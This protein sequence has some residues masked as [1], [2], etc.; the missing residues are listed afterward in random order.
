MTPDVCP[1]RDLLPQ[2]RA[3]EERARRGFDQV[4][5]TKNELLRLLQEAKE[6]HDFAVNQAYIRAGS[7]AEHHHREQE[8]DYTARREIAEHEFRIGLAKGDDGKSMYPN[9]GARSSGVILACALDSTYKDAL[10][11]KLAEA[12]MRAADTSEAEQHAALAR[13]ERAFMRALAAIAGMEDA[14]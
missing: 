7:A 1:A 6:R 14:E 2:L 4:I 9:E 5:N 10:G 3:S 11:E 12:E 13:G 8:A